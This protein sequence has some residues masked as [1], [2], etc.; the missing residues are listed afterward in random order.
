[1]SENYSGLN[2]AEARI[3]QDIE[4]VSKVYGFDPGTLITIILPI[5]MEI[6]SNCILK[7]GSSS[8]KAN[9]NNEVLATFII[10]KA[11]P[12]EVNGKPIPQS[13]ISELASR[14]YKSASSNFGDLTDEIDN[15]TSIANVW[16]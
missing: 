5:L 1:M 15:A 10:R 16:D 9:F 2:A 8:V 12:K 7:Q 14:I 4:D 3:K 11:L 6:I 13:A